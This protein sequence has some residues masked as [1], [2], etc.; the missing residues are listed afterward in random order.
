MSNEYASYFQL[1]RLLALQQTQAADLEHNELLF[2]TVHQSHELWF[3]L[4]VHELEKLRDRLIDGDSP[5]AAAAL[6][7][8]ATIFRALIAQLETLETMTPDAFSE[9]RPLLEETS[10]FQSYQF[11]EMEFLLGK[12]STGTLR[13]YPEGGAIRQR[14][15][16]RLKEPTIQ[17]AFLRHLVQGGYPLEDEVLARCE[18]APMAE[19]PRVQPVLIKLYQ[20][21]SPLVFLCEKLIN[22]DE[23]FQEWRYRHIKIVER[24]I[25]S[26]QGTGGSTGAD[27]LKT[28][29]F[30]PLFPDLWAIR[31]DI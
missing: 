17:W 18:T 27:Y 3:K 10:G 26:K 8:L 5:A 25:G 9:I 20:Q 1:D 2:I 30:K 11:R 6:E 21:R 22:I 23:G 24:F 12:R 4:A 14:L 15:E 7:R 13:Y 29:L 16:Q 19:N 28:T 31:S